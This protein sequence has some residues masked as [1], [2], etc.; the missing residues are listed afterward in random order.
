MNCEIFIEE[1]GALYENYCKM[2]SESIKSLPIKTIHGSFLA[3]KGLYFL[4]R[5]FDGR[6]YQANFDLVVILDR[7]GRFSVPIVWLPN[8][9][10][11][12]K[13]EHLYND[14]TCCLGL[15]FEVI[16]IWGQK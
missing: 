16:K 7:T 8:E 5:E 3:I 10:R 11:P 14:N 12:Y 9:Q 4:N 15:A 2:D 13:F 1:A 6:V